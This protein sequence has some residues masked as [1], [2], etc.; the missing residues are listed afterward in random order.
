M[1]LVASHPDSI[2]ILDNK[3][4]ESKYEFQVSAKCYHMDMVNN[5]GSKTPV[6][7]FFRLCISAKVLLNVP[8]Y[9]HYFYRQKKPI[10]KKGSKKSTSKKGSKKTVMQEFKGY[11]KSD[12]LKEICKI[13]GH[14][15]SYCRFGSNGMIR[16]DKISNEILFKNSIIAIT[17]VKHPVKYA[18]HSSLTGVVGDSI[19]KKLKE[20]KIEIYDIYFKDSEYHE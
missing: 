6:E 2:K 18:W 11:V 20:N 16:V 10:S 9:C 7:N 4:G 8:F 12:N 3:P 17:G 19:L 5:L 1:L 15:T 14:V 13:L